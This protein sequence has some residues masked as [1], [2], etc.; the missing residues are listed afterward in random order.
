MKKI[1]L[2]IISFICLSCGNNQERYGYTEEYIMYELMMDELDYHETYLNFQITYELSKLLTDGKMDSEIEIVD[3]ITKKYQKELGRIITYLSTNDEGEDLLILEAFDVLK[4]T[5][6]SN[7]YFF[8]GDS[9]S[10]NGKSLNFF[11]DRYR[12][13]VRRYFDE[14]IYLKRISGT[15]ETSPVKRRNGT[16][17]EPLFYYYKDMP[18]IAVITHLKQQRNYSL[19]FELQYLLKK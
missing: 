12:N 1:M 2:G 19:E 8:H 4:R 10:N 18:L 13:E 14:P 9:L 11:R 5:D 16:G 15:L 6:K 17:I 3:S 7:R